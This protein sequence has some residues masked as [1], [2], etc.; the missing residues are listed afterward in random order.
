VAL[1]GVDEGVE[2][3]VRLLNF[4]VVNLSDGEERRGALGVAVNL[5]RQPVGGIIAESAGRSTVGFETL[6]VCGAY[7]AC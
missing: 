1:D 4:A 2:A 7:Q 6:P 5:L 3:L